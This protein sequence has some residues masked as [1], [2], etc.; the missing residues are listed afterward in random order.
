MESE[1]FSCVYCKQLFVVGNGLLFTANKQRAADNQIEQRC[2]KINL[3]L[4][5]SA[6]GTPSLS[7]KNFCGTVFW[8]KQV[9]LKRGRTSRQTLTQD[10]LER[11]VH[12]QLSVFD[13]FLH[14]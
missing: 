6:S 7:S 9:C 14:S 12:D 3:T 4:N 2:L 5:V 13:K 1:V 11:T 10:L 8:L